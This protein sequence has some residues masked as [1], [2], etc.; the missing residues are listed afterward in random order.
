MGETTNNSFDLSWGAE[1]G[2][3]ESLPSSAPSSPPQV[4]AMA[5]RPTDADRR[6]YADGEEAAVH[7]LEAHQ[8][9]IEDGL[10]RR[11]IGTANALRECRLRQR[12]G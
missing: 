9:H 2:G 12:D 5:Q 8:V 6:A 10:R 4:L 11:V 1:G 7:A 3:E